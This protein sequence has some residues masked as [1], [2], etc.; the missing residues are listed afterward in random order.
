M[1]AEADQDWELKVLACVRPTLPMGFPTG[2]L[3]RTL[4]YRQSGL[5]ETPMLVERS[6]KDRPPPFDTDTLI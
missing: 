6:I 1:Q 3:L 2:E 5:V 4:S